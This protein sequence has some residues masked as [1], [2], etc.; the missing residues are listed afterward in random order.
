MQDLGLM[1]FKISIQE[2]V[3]K[4]CFVTATSKEEALKLVEVR[5]NDNPN[6]LGEGEVESANFELIY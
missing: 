6:F 1:E 4:E 3:T 5:Y 2:I